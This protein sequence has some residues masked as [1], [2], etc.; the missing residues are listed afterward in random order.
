MITLLALGL[1]A[2]AQSVSQMATVIEVHG[3]ARF[4]TD[5]KNWQPVRNGSVFGAGAVVQTADNSILTF[6]LGENA[7][8]TVKMSPDS[9]IAI[10]S[11]S[12]QSTASGVS[13]DFELDLRDGQIT[14]HSRKPSAQSHYEIKFQNGVAGVRDESHYRINS[15]GQVDAIT[16]SLIVSVMAGGNANAMIVTAGNRLNPGTWTTS[17]IPADAAASEPSKPQPASPSNNP[18]TTA[19]ANP[20]L[21]GPGLGGSLRKF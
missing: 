15:F 8:D 14:G 20:A 7:S 6:R 1:E 19:P 9:V 10:D 16:G 18:Q 21:K 13:E 17:A 12:S 5:K 2:G 3:K 11:L 4:S